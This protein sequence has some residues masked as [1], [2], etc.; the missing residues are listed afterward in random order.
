[1]Q[2]THHPINP[3]TKIDRPLYYENGCHACFVC[4]G[5]FRDLSSYSFHKKE[6]VMPQY[7][8]GDRMSEPPPCDCQFW[9]KVHLECQPHYVGS[10]YDDPCTQKEFSWKN[11]WGLLNV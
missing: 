9:Y 8:E 5:P 2:L 7:L 1:M 4:K 11:L 10:P 3:K 6:C